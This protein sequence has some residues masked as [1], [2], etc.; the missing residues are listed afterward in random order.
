MEKNST[1]ILLFNTAMGLFRKNG[2][3][4]VTI[5][6]ICKQANVTRNAFYYYFESKED[7]MSSYFDN[8]PDFTHHLLTGILPLPNDWEKLWYIFESHLKLI[9]SEGLSICRTLIKV[10]LDGNGTFLTQ[11]YISESV[12]I[13][14]LRNCQQQGLVHNMMD[15]QQLIYLAMRMVVGVLLTWCGSNGNFPLI[16]EA[17]NAF[18]VLLSPTN[19]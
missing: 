7:L 13:P 15:P 1:K 2:Y 6:Q 5:Q 9:E 8:I 4:N 16:A 11:Y 12:S 10:S 14:L 3:D 18:C 19:A 17:K